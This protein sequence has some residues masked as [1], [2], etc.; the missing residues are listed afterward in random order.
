MPTARA[1]PIRVCAISRQTGNEDAIRD[2]LLTCRWLTGAA[3]ALTM[4]YC[5]AEL[6]QVLGT[7]EWALNRNRWN[8]VLALG[9]AIDR[10]LTL[11]GLWDA[12]GQVADQVLQ[13]ARANHN[14]SAEA[15]ALHQLGTR[16]VST[17]RSQA[18]DLLKQAL[19]LR[20]SKATTA[21]RSRAQSDILVH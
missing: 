6:G 10:Y 11:H 4:M 1:F 2:R 17:D 15:W 19:H 3:V 21:R 8:D 14:H 20:L 7:L 13:A 5:A 9:H 12:W 18:I 16:A